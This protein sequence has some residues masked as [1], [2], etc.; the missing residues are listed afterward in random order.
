M[1]IA[2]DHC[3]AMTMR[4]GRKSPVVA[5]AL[6]L[7][8]CSSSSTSKT[9]GSGGNGQDAAGV[10]GMSGMG[11]VSRD[12]A[13][14]SGG[15]QGRGGT[16]AMGGVPG[17]GGKPASGGAV[18]NG[19]A[20]AGKTGNGGAIGKGGATGSGGTG[21][22]GG[23]TGGKTGGAPGT[24]GTT[25]SGVDGG[26]GFSASYFIGADI[27]W[28]QADEARGATYSDGSKRDIL[29]ILKDHGFNFIR[30]RTFV[31]PK[32]ADGYDKSGYGDLAHT[33]A[34]GKRIK[35]AGM[36]F[37][38][39]FHYSDNWADPGKQ[40]VPVAWQGA[41]TIDEL[42]AFVHD[43]SKDAITQLVAGGAR[44][45]MVQVGNEIT[46]GMLL[47]V[48]DSGGQP[49]GNA[50]ITG[51]SSNWGNLGALLKAGV[52]GVKDVDPGIK[53]MLHIDKCGDKASESAGS[54]LKTS[55]SWIQSAQK[56][57][58]SFDVFG[59]SCYQRYQ[60]DPNSVANSK[61]TWTST[62]GGLAKAFPDLQFVA[63]E[64]GPA[65]RE[66]NDVVFGLPGGQGL[67]TFN[68]EPTHQGDW[69][70]GHVLFSA[71]GNSYTATADLDLYDLMKVDYKSRL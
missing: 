30:L 15:N 16:V 68:W 59:E 40:C 62:L 23:M 12:A 38:L 7:S 37:L 31:D 51:S 35:A 25:G 66:I 47:H 43:Y 32:A 45:D 60:G 41:T 8:A 56:Q 42:A 4:R 14:A 63:A 64:Y 48:C 46:P 6:V 44:P 13:Q 69:N 58:V 28:V 9:P 5:L 61:A 24:G 2:F 22:I 18:G 29:Q 36:G 49:T 34:F 3:P 20:T 70:T 55:T 1:I 39:D 33:L 19:G 71:S 52:K 67:G 17:S 10:G 27:T 53:I 11:G 65:Q 57:G 26:A 54:A 50:K 21:K